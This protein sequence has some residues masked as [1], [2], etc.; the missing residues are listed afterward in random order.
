MRMRGAV[1]AVFLVAVVIAPLASAAAAGDGACAQHEQKYLHLLNSSEIYLKPVSTYWHELYPDYCNKYH[2]IDW[3]DNGDEVL[4]PCDCIKLENIKN[5]ERPRWY[6][7]DNVTITLLALRIPTPTPIPTLIPIPTPIPISK[8]SSTDTTAL[9]AVMRSMYIEFTGG[10]D[11]IDEVLKKPVCTYWHE[12]YPNFCVSYHLRDWKDNGDGYLSAGDFISL[13]SA[14][15]ISVN[16]YVKEVKTDIVV[17]P[18]HNVEIEK[19]VKDPETG[20]WVPRV[21]VP[22]CTNIK[23]R[24]VIRNNDIGVLRNISV[25]DVLSDG[26]DYNNNATVSIIP[27]G[28]VKKWRWEPVKIGTNKYLWDLK[29][30]SLSPRD[31]LMIEYDAHVFRAGEDTNYVEM[32]GTLFWDTVASPVYDNSSAFIYGVGYKPAVAVSVDKYEYAAGDE[33]LINLT[34]VNPTNCTWKCVFTRCLET[35]IGKFFYKERDITLPPLYDKTF[36]FTWKVPSV[37]VPSAN[38]INASWHVSLLNPEHEGFICE[39]V[40]P[41][42]YIGKQ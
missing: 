30:I 36:S 24:T 11:E 20:E 42:L 33:M 19:Y 31:E 2:V 22:I 29:N 8:V 37:P 21:K 7:V 9:T 6:H 34:L 25:V 13:S 10:Y 18:R 35:D 26:L 23:F 28:K 14:N 32:N 39:D 1:M 5:E 27:I 16:Y 4:S 12:V 15:G 38:T 3:R 41:W 40:A 17:S